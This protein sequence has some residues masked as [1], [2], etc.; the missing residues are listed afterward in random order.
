M[1]NL[2]ST[3]IWEPC[4]HLNLSFHEIS[5]WNLHFL[6]FESLRIWLGTNNGFG[7]PSW[8][9]LACVTW[10]GVGGT[11]PSTRW[12]FQTFY[13]SPGSLTVRPWKVPIGKDRLPTIIFQG[14]TVQLR[15]CNPLGRW[16]NLEIFFSTGWLLNHHFRWP[17]VTNFHVG[18]RWKTMPKP[19][20]SSLQKKTHGDVNCLRIAAVFSVLCWDLIFA[21]VVLVPVPL[22][23]FVSQT[24]I[25]LEVLD[26]C[27]LKWLIAFQDHEFLFFCGT[28]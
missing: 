28:G 19:N 21:Y 27:F 22:L 3:N 8:W 18:L 24:A 1:R 17:W 7:V 6:S 4:V 16:S 20:M 5:S 13:M 23:D 2:Q 15:G 25:V 11:T 9:L 26:L 14:R 12:C 10:H